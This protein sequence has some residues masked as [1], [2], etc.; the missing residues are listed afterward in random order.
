MVT[1][2]AN[3]TSLD[4]QVVRLKELFNRQKY[5]YSQAVMPTAEQ[6]IGHLKALKRVTIKFQDQLAA[7]INKDFSSRS[8]DETLIAE[9][10][11]S[12]ESINMAIKK[13]RTWM[14]PSKR[15]VGI[16]FAPAKN[17]VHYQP[18]G[19]IGIIVPWNYP[20]V[21]ALGPLVAAL[22]AGNRA[23]IK[24]SEFTPT[25]NKVFKEMNLLVT[26]VKKEKS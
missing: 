21:L 20:I 1:N 24:M 4:T 7:A 5:A 11:T 15:S 13:T 16:L 2:T 6:R 22:A 8:K 14:K 23:M 25:L 17:E 26:L 19:V 9:I 10:L 3:I 18:L 12:V